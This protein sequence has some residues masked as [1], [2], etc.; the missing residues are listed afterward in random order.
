MRIQE[1]DERQS[2]PIKFLWEAGVERNI[3]CFSEKEK[4]SMKCRGVREQGLNFM[5]FIRIEKKM[6]T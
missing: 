5:L 6:E 1:R 2:S 3:K 4:K